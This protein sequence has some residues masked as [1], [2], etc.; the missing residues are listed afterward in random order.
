MDS[1]HFYHTENNQHSP[2][3]A[4]KVQLFYLAGEFYHSKINRMLIQTTKEANPL[5][6]QRQRY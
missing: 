4:E 1:A 6:I 2:Q 3:E 5:Q